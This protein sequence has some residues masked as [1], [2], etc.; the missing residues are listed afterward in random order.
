MAENVLKGQILAQSTIFSVQ[1]TRHKRK[2][3]NCHAYARKIAKIFLKKA[4]LWAKCEPK[5]TKGLR[6]KKT[7]IVPRRLC[8]NYNF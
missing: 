3:N 6:K 4:K 2:I 5:M 8:E 1:I 7:K